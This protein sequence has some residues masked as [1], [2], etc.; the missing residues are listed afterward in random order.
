MAHPLQDGVI[1]YIAEYSNQTDACIAHHP[2]QSFDLNRFQEEFG[3]VSPDNPMLD[4]YPV[5]E[6][7]VH[8][9]AGYLKKNIKWNFL[10]HSYYLESER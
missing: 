1:R 5:F 4:R 8:F 7:S 6:T 3:I 2:L 10:T 9:L